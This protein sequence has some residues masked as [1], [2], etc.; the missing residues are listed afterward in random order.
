MT[1]RDDT[2]QGGRDERVVGRRDRGAERAAPPAPSLSERLLAARERK[3]VDLSRAERDTKIRARYLAAL[4]RGDFKELPGT[5]YTKGFLR[6][7]ALYLGLDPDE[8]L[9]QWRRERGDHAAANEPA[10]IVPRALEV[11]RQGITI[12]RGV[13]VAGLLTLGVLAFVVYLVVQ[14]DRFLQAPSVTVTDPSVAVSEVDETT[15][16]YTLRGTATP[17]A[18]VAIDTPGRETLR[19][20]A[21]AGGVWSADVELRRGRNQFDISA[22]D[23]ETGKSTQEPRRIF[24]TVP[25]SEALVPT[26]EVSSPVDGATYENGAIPI[27]GI[28]T[29]GSTVRVGAAW[30]GS[31]DAVVDSPAP[32]ATPSPPTPIDARVADDGS[33]STAVD[34]TAGRWIITI[35]ASSSQGRTI[36]IKRTV[37]VSYSGVNLAVEIKGGKAWLK[38]WVDGQIDPGT[39]SSG[40]VFDPGRTLT[41]TGRESVE[42]RTGSSG[43]TY[44]SLNGTSLGALG[45]EG[46]P[47]TWLFRPTGPPTQTNRG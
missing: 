45:Q 23:P 38:V 34:L 24:I 29:N 18:T 6:N 42:V 10:I 19:V 15:S 35:T 32:S 7:Y 13:L 46:I 30:N 25:L 11:P 26:L 9:G 3:G 33:F 40:K 37:T 20:T 36:S 39:G 27:Q 5:V 16:T 43:N 1:A 12:G 21:S 44:F 8:V 41:F 28:T 17:G 4:E 47:E 2:R 14:V 31:A 22:T